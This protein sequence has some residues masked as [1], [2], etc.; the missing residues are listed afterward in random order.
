MEQ[1]AFPITAWFAGPKAE[2]G[3]AFARTLRRILEDNQYWRRNYFPEDGVVITSETRRRQSAWEDLFEDRLIELLALLKA[4]VPFQSPRY[5]AHM[6]AEQ[7]LPSIAGYL[8]AMLYNPN[9]VSTEAA[10]VTV[11]LE[12]AAARMIAEMLGYDPATCWAHLTGGGTVAN[13]EAL[14]AARLVRY[15]PVHLKDVLERLDLDHPLRSEDV[16][17]LLGYRPDRALRLLT[18]V[19]D[20]AEARWGAGAESVQRVLDAY[21]ASEYNVAQVG[22]GPLCARLGTE[23][24]LLV[25]ASHHYSFPKAM[26]LMGL[27]KRNI[28]RVDV[29]AQFRM[30]VADL[31]ARLDA[32]EAE[33]RHVLAVV[34]IVGTTEEGAI[35]PVDQ[36]VALREER[37]AAGRPSFWLHADA[38]Y[39]GYLRT[40][41]RPRRMDVGAPHTEVEIDGRRHRLA[42][43][44]PSEKT[45]Y[46]LL[47][48]GACDSIIVDPHK[49]GYIPYPA[50]A[51]CFKN[52]LIRPVLRQTAPYIEEA[53]E[54]PRQETARESIGVYILEGSKPGAA[55]AAVWLSHSTIPLDNTGHGRL[56]R[57][58]IRNA[59]ELH[60]LLTEWPRLGP[61]SDGPAMQA[62]P[63]C[64]PDSNIVC[65]AF[66]PA[67]PGASL[68]ALNTLNRDLYRRFSI[69]VEHRVPVYNMRYFLSR[70]MLTRAQYRTP[71]VRGF[72]ERLGVSPEEYEAHGVFLLRSVLM[73]PWYGESKRYGHYYLVDLVRTLYAEAA[74][75]W[76][77]ESPA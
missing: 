38:A 69:P 56:I 42:L 34:T 61:P 66:R 54:A 11:R 46:A 9:N 41:I 60:A 35:D 24:V 10:P 17:A 29:D 23:P 53:P 31:R 70:T 58:T 44:L 43:P 15:L 25:P 48:L 1:D 32:V 2:N 64:P 67:A 40:T 65:Y 12:L 22:V 13:F 62:V 49:L 75:R 37:E 21:A 30:D 4:D 73:N 55:A 3:E 76:P 33:G 74:R 18:E 59:C 52:H 77:A 47:K 57:E 14:W 20:A 27:G 39:G 50:G 63:L 51:V 7:T 5:A 6:V 28:V 16:P 8:A 36:V 72:L 45:R 71:V 19:F 26:D 68:E